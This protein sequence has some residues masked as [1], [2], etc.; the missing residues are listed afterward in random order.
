MTNKKP[1]EPLIALML[2]ML[3]PGL[4]QIYSGYVKN[5]TSIIYV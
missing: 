5:G 1:K 4:G 2:T 3:L